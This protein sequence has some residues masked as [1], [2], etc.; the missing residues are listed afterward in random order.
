[1]SQV[2]LGC[3]STVDCPAADGCLSCR[4]LCAPPKSVNHPDAT[5]CLP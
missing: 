2:T 1:M 4:P 5:A 3:V